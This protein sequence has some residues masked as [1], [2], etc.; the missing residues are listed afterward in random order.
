MHGGLVP[1]SID[2]SIDTRTA[3]VDRSVGRSRAVPIPIDPNPQ[4][5]NPQTP[6]ELESLDPATANVYKMM[7][8]ALLRVELEDARQNVAKRL[9][10]IKTQMY[11]VHVCMVFV[12]YMCM[13]G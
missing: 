10:L 11:V 7:G 1:L 4:I 13:E 5:P 12:Y 2:W 3:W 8:P 9:E 6:K